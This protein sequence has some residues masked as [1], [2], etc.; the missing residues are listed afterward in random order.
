[1]LPAVL[2]YLTYIINTIITKSDFPKNWKYAKIIPIPKSN[3]DF[4]P[5]AILPYLSKVCE[6]LLHQQMNKYLHDNTL[7]TD[8][9]SGFR[10]RHSCVT[11]LIDVSEDIR[12]SID[13]GDIC[14]L[15]LLDHSKAFDT[16]DHNILCTKL[17][18]MFNF[19]SSSTN[20]ISS[21]LSGH[22]QSVF[23]NNQN[24]RALPVI[25]GVPQ[26]SILGPLLFSIYINDLVKHL[27]YCRIHLYAD[28]V[29]IYINSKIDKITTC[30]DKLNADL[31]NVHTWAT[32]NGL[33]INPSKSK[34]L[35]ITRK[36]VNLI[37]EPTVSINNQPIQVVNSTK[38][39]GIIFNNT[40]SWSDHINAAAGKTYS[41][42]RTL[43]T[44]QYLTPL[45][46]RILLAKTYLIPSLLYGC[47][48]FANLDSTTKKKLTVTYN[49][50]LRYVFN[51][52]KYDHIS[53][54]EKRLF[55]VNI[56]DLLEIRTLLLFHKILFT[57]EPKYLFNRLVPTRSRRYND[58]IQIRYRTSFSEHH[59]YIFAIRLW[60]ELPPNLQFI[61]NA[62]Q[63][64]KEIFKHY[65]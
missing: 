59:F 35:I 60:N 22:Y 19:S 21:Y 44:T 15:V 13:D 30:V 39:L 28:D 10:N 9:Q 2:P 29:Q 57:C 63:F 52:R 12:E 34:C 31:A 49:S 26:G 23:S 7:L 3:N 37:T 61:S 53:A 25:K 48:V 17:L 8:R 43:W 47:E 38:N 65:N 24:S 42:I 36:S 51:L 14:F 45:N 27:S 33:C 20:L 46:I 58:M 4:R 41:M 16:V 11:A 64:K 40:L 32:A 6:K 54:F 56:I 62:L 55:G 18:T 5:V 50:I 1:M